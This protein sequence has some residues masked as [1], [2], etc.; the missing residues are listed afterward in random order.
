MEKD[1]TLIQKAP[2]RALR[3]YSNG[4]LAEDSPNE[5]T[6]NDSSPLNRISLQT[7]EI[8]ISK[9]LTSKLQALNRNEQATIFM[10]MLGALNVLFY[11]YNPDEI[12]VGIPFVRKEE[13]GVERPGILFNGVVPLKNKLS[14]EYSFVEL[15]KEIKTGS[16][17]ASSRDDHPRQAIEEKIITK[18]N[19]RLSEFSQVMLVVSAVDEVS[20]LQFGILQ[21]SE[22]PVTLN[23]SKPEIKF[24]IE[25]TAGTLKGFVEYNTR[26]YKT[27][28]IVRM[29]RHFTELLVSIANS[30]GKK[31]SKLNLL[32]VEEE[33]QLLEKF[34]DTSVTYPREKSIINLFEE[35]VI[36]NPGKI[37]AIFE[38]EKLTYED[39]NKRSNQLARY[40]IN[41]GVQRETLIPICIERSLEMLIGILGILKAGAAYVPIDPEYPIDRISYM[42]TDTAAG[43]IVTSKISRTKLPASGDIKIVE[44]DRHRSPIYDMPTLN[45]GINISSHNLA[46]VIYTSGSTGKPKG[47]MIEHQAVLDHCFGL[48]K[49]AQLDTC[50][51]FALF[52]PLVFDAGHS[53][54]FTSLFLGASLNILSHELIMDG[55]KL[56]TYLEKNPVDCI[57][58]VPSVWLSYIHSDNEVLANKVMIFGGETFSGKIQEHLVRLNYEAIVYNHYGPTEATIGKC[59]HKVDLKREY[60]T[61]PI[62]KPFSNTQLYVVDQLDHIVPIGIAGELYIAGEG[63]AREYLNRPHLSEEKFIENPFRTRDRFSIDN[64]S[65]SK[66]VSRLY[67]TGDKVRWNAYGEIEYLGRIDEQV[68][69]RG[70]RIELGE[71]ENV[72]LQNEKIKQAAVRLNED[73]YG[74]KILVGYIAP[75]GLVDKQQIVRQLKEK[76]PEYMI[77]NLWIKL[78]YFPLT[79]NGK[80]DKK[81]LP[82]PDVSELL[83]NQ[84]SAPQNDTEVALVKIWENLLGVKKVGIYDTFFE[85]GGNSIQAVTMFTRIR[86][87]FGRELPLAT[88]FQAPDINKLTAVINQKDIGIKLS[89]LIPIQPLGFKA[90]LFCMHAGA[91]NVLFYKDLAKNLGTDQPLYGLQARGLNGKEQ[92]H[93]CIE[94]MASY[95]IK[96]I[97]TVQPKGPYQLVGYCFGGIVAFEMAQQLTKQGEK[98]SFLT[99]INGKA[100]MHH[101]VNANGNSSKNE[102]RIPESSFFVRHFKIFHQL[103]TLEKMSYPFQLLRNKTRRIKMFYYFK[104]RTRLHRQYSKM[105]KIAYR[106]YFSRNLLLP[107]FLR[108]KYL[109]DETNT[110]A[111]VY[112]PGIY[113]GRFIVFRSPHIFSDPYLGWS[114]YV[115]QNIISYDIVGD[116][117][118]RQDVM[119]EPYVKILADKIKTILESSEMN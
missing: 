60:K 97:R 14:D 61:V 78:D 46:Y 11:R 86:K 27:D 44:I 17:Q 104:L 57:K 33:R 7:E 99:T 62:G 52:S 50:S 106:F 8:S 111:E 110:M 26:L 43:V 58:I 82:V 2:G 118:R 20:Q 83:H 19:L 100:P 68:K 107:P 119:M 35:E 66:P 18:Q 48:I 45:P 9:E 38:D 59:I 1:K 36:K 94:D 117:N 30:P 113:H 102:T 84:Y 31:I 4:K 88:I 98:I 13:A 64:L 115:S 51:S 87:H 41:I 34:N 16:L 80:I 6:I 81:A 23:L 56:V 3:K 93:T 70:H 40:L 55:E 92:F 72:L 89:C 67:K 22:G 12:C 73:N 74:N 69:L 109:W 39:L 10:T 96:E 95:Y 53:I 85:L 79:P 91:G 116:Y 32:P 28:R 90:P 29:I 75:Q 63:I 112:K 37:A 47:V 114:K 15:L 42:L 76:L 49:A 21:L 77:P 5:L 103:S 25:E 65:R 101:N 71:I 24:F 105:R 108:Y 54:I